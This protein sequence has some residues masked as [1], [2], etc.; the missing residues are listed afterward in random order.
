MENKE[1]CSQFDLYTKFMHKRCTGYGDYSEFIKK[2]NMVYSI[3]MK[4]TN[5]K[6]VIN[7][8]GLFN[9][10]ITDIN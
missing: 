6:K 2:I 10:G 9:I 5:V 7:V 4:L 8:F 3:V 1:Y